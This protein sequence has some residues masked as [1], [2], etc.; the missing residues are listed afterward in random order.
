[1]QLVP[2]R[3]T[4]WPVTP[5]WETYHT[6]GTT[7]SKAFLGSCIR[8]QGC[9]QPHQFVDQML[10][11]VQD[12][13]RFRHTPVPL[14]CRSPPTLTGLLP[15][16]HARLFPKKIPFGLALFSAREYWKPVGRLLPTPEPTRPL[17]PPRLRPPP[18]PPIPR[19]LHRRRARNFWRA[20]VAALP[21]TKLNRSRIV[22][23]RHNYRRPASQRRQNLRERG[24]WRPA[25]RDSQRGTRP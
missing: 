22:T 18:P 19:P 3:C 21:R 20:A 23:Q 25:H 24:G 13:V 12:T 11:P 9:L 16:H 5:G 17:P 10:D 2:I 15:P 7:K 6:L 14:T 1:M 8:R 4:L